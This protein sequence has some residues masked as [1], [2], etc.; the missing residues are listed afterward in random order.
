VVWSRCIQLS[1]VELSDIKPGA[2]GA[3]KIFCA[4]LESDTNP[5]SSG[6]VLS[7]NGVGD[8]VSD[9]LGGG[10]G[11]GLRHHS[12]LDAGIGQAELGTIFS[13]CTRKQV[14]VSLNQARDDRP[15]AHVHRLGPGPGQPSHLLIG[16]Q[17]HNPFAFDGHRFKDIPWGI[18]DNTA[19][20]HTDDL[21]IDQD[22]VGITH[23]FH[24]SRVVLG[25]TRSG[26]EQSRNKKSEKDDPLFTHNNL[27]SSDVIHQMKKNFLRILRL[28]RGSVKR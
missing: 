16:S 27:R 19:V 2:V 1:S 7:S 8:R 10:L 12:Q 15:L 3:R 5:L 11:R 4:F 22:G 20:I 24:Q 9:A 25:K 21:P 13:G 17:G 23:I 14:V 26:Q 6:N 18:G 28:T